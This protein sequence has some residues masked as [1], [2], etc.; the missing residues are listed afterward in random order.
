[1]VRCGPS[2]ETS[3][4]FSLRH[5]RALLDAKEWIITRKERVRGL[6]VGL[7]AVSN[8]SICNN[9]L[10][11]GRHHEDL[12]QLSL[13]SRPQNTKTVQIHLMMMQSK[14]LLRTL[15]HMT[16]PREKSFIL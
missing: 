7:A 12:L 13:P 3:P 9:I 16:H 8:I 4:C 2:L 15:V 14:K 1:M 5:L 10:R 6:E 11:T